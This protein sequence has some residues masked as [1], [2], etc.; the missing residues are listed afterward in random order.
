MNVV[1]IGVQIASAGG[2]LLIGALLLLLGLD[3]AAKSASRFPS[4]AQQVT[5]VPAAWTSAIGRPLAG[6]VVC[7]PSRAP[8]FLQQRRI[9][10]A[11]SGGFPRIAIRQ[12]ASI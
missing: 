9:Q 1:Q 11:A 12:Y 4:L 10:P 2:I 8:P 5:L 7:A 3:F 6:L